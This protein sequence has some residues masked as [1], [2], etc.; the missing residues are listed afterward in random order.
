[1]NGRVGQNMSKN[2]KRSKPAMVGLSV[3][4]P[5]EMHAI[6]KQQAADAHMSLAD[7]ARLW[8][9]FGKRQSFSWLRIK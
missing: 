6:M 4:I 1:M 3:L 5:A 7:I 8:L 2:H 9:E